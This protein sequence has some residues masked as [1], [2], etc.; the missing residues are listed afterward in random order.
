MTHEPNERN[1]NGLSWADGPG[2]ID[3]EMTNAA[4]YDR[5]A[6]LTSLAGEL[7]IER[8]AQAAS[9]SASRRMAASPGPGGRIGDVLIGLGTALGGRPIQ[10]RR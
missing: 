5:I 6:D 4:V 9:T 1:H 8:A 2:G 7:R 3:M 10:A